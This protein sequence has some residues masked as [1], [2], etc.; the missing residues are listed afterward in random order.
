[1]IGSDRSNNSL[2]RLLR[3]AAARCLL[4]AAPLGI[5]PAVVLTS[6]VPAHA[7]SYTFQDI[8]DPLNPTFTQALGINGSGTI[9]GYGNATIFNGFTLTLPS[10]FTRLN[11][12][13]ADGG[14]QVT[15]IDAAGDTV[16]FSITGGVTAGFANTGGQGG[17]FTRVFDPPFAFTQLLG[18]SSN[19]ATAAGY[20][21][22]DVTGLTEQI[23][24]TVSGGPGF[25]S[26]TFTGINSLLPANTNSQ[27]TGVNDTGEVVGFYQEGPNASPTFHGFTDIGG[28]ITPFL[29]PGSVSTQALGVND[30]GEIVGDYVT[31]GVMH[32]FL[33]NAGT[34]TTLDP[35]GSTATTING[36]NDRGTVVGFYMNANGATI[37]TEGTM[38]PEPSTWAMMLAGFAGLGFLGYR[39]VRQGKLAA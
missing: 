2:F 34:F 28:S 39:K 27:A 21:T 5:A 9:A 32:G 10:S 7:G 37:G 23:A 8:I 25:A 14:T 26:P 15:G 11:V 36:I 29:V 12:A 22:H 38:V 33:D 24:G 18:I 3:G 31:G 30:L 17:T 6:A 35:T 16:G 20:W 19:G 13:G 4:V 1:M